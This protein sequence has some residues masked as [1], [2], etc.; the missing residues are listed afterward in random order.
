MPDDDVLAENIRLRQELELLR[1]LLQRQG[2]E[3]SVPLPEPECPEEAVTSLDDSKNEVQNSDPS[4][5][6]HQIHQIDSALEVEGSYPYSAS[7]GYDLRKKQIFAW[8]W[9]DEGGIW[10]EYDPDIC[11]VLSLSQISFNRTLCTF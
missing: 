4:S 8:S 9:Q 1:S 2:T 10:R 11:E 6:K 5:E 3:S 7:S